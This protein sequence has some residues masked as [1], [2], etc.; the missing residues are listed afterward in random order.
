MGAARY[1]P[2]TLNS[3]QT[4]LR[5]AEMTINADR[6]NDALV[7]AAQ[8]DAEYEARKLLKVTELSRKSGQAG[9]ELLA[10]DVFNRDEQISQLNNRMSTTESELSE[11]QKSTIEA[12]QSALKAQQELKSRQE[13]EAV[14]ANVQKQFSPQEAEVFRQGDNLILRLKSLNFASGRADIPASAFPILKKV[15]SAIQQINTKKVVVEGHA[16]A[17]G[18]AAVNQKI[19]Q[20]RADSVARYLESAGAGLTASSTQ[21]G[22]STTSTEPVIEAQGYSYEHPLANNKTKKGRALNRRVDIVIMAH[23]PVTGE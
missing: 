5:N 6:H 22:S 3:A 9:N 7:S 13:A 10:L 14:I 15:S 12:Q 17:T 16:D 19:S 11:A 21:T 23:S 8:S 1:A 4:K 18:S 20:E 2:R